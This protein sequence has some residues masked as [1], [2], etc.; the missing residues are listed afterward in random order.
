VLREL[1]SWAI[2]LLFAEE[3]STT[4]IHKLQLMKAI[5]YLETETV[6]VVDTAAQSSAADEDPPP[7]Q[8]EAAA[9][10]DTARVAAENDQMRAELAE[11]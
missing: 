8:E 2:P 6:L 9:A 4:P 5:A 7:S 10:V 1:I 3:L 11:G